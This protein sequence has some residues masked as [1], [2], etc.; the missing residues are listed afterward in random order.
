MIQDFFITTKNTKLPLLNLKG[1]PYLAV[2]WRILW[3]REDHPD[4]TFDISYPI[5]NDKM[6][7]AKASIIDEKG[8][9]RATAHKVEHFA[10]FA[11]AAE[12]A[13][14][15]SIGR[16]LGM[17]GYGTQFA[18]ELE[19]ERLAD[20]PLDIGNNRNQQQQVKQNTSNLN[21]NAVR[22]QEPDKP[23]N[24]APMGPGKLSEAQI[25]RFYALIKKAAWTEEDAKSCLKLNF[26]VEKSSDLS[27]EQYDLFCSYLNQ[28]KTY[29]QVKSLPTIINEGK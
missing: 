2:A 24:H 20:A 17:I 5:L 13:E 12:K 29:E 22:L 27:K 15:G 26:N 9:L 14:T 1:K 28:G 11:D 18:L 4:W 7:M 23:L 19:D 25:K 3:F 10:H 16:A 6:A 8:V 21:K